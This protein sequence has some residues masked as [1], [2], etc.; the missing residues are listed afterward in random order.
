LRRRS[1]DY[2]F[3]YINSIPDIS[4]GLTGGLVVGALLPIVAI[5]LLTVH[6]TVVALSANKQRSERA[7]I[8][9]RHLLDRLCALYRCGRIRR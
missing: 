2:V 8:V 7:P 5:T 6:A 1:E 3:S 4:P 9:L